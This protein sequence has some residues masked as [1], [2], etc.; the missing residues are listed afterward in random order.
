MSDAVKEVNSLSSRGAD[1]HLLSLLP[2]SLPR[3]FPPWRR[4]LIFQLHFGGLR[5]RGVEAGGSGEMVEQVGTV[6]RAVVWRL[7]VVRC[8]APIHICMYAGCRRGN[9]AHYDWAAVSYRVTRERES[10][11]L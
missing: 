11:Q 5:W 4:K 9:E 8:D 2:C 6:A 10:Y 7:A 3:S 1:F